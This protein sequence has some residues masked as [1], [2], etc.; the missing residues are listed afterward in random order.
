MKPSHE[1]TVEAFDDVNGTNYRG[2]WLASRA[3]LGH[4]LSQEPLPTHDGRPGNRGCVVNIA[5]NL[6]L[7]SRPAARESAGRLPLASPG[8]PG[9]SGRS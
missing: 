3:V 8:R 7:V 2:V 5:S 4:M 6:G 1:L 9:R